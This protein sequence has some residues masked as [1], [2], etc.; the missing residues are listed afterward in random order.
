MNQHAEADRATGSGRRNDGSRPAVTTPSAARR[1]VADLLDRAGISL[2]S[3]TAADAL[4]VATELVTNAIRH[5]GGITRFHTAVT[6]DVLHLS[7]SDAN[8]RAPFPRPTAPGRPGGYGWPL[9]QR[10]TDRIEVRARPGGKTVHA[11]LRLL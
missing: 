11:V 1:T 4:L 6:D 3:V 9:V 5:G 2:D 8:P 10:L 7:V